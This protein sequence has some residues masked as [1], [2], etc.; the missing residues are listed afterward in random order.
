[1]TTTFKTTVKQVSTYLLTCAYAISGVDQLP[2]LTSVTSQVRT[3]YGVKLLDCAVVL[4]A[5]SFTV[6]V[7]AA[8]TLLLPVGAHQ[9]DIV[10][11]YNDGRVAKTPTWE[12]EVQPLVTE[13]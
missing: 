12:V 11:R 10:Y 5:Q 1:M 4:A 2:L 13:S 7:A 8:D 9:Q 6:S 3:R